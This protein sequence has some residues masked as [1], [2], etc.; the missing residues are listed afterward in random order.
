MNNQ[1]GKNL[2]H[3][4]K[5]L[6]LSQAEIAAI[7]SKAPSSIGNWEAFRSEPTLSDLLAITNHFKISLDD[8]MKK[9]LTKYSE[10]EIHQLQNEGSEKEQYLET[11]NKFKFEINAIH[12]MLSKVD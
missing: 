11:I 2:Y 4:R 10:D 1:F 6:D 7:V 9:D 12:E 8:L 3:V 5:I